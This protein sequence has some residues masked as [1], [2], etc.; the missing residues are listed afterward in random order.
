MDHYLAGNEDMRAYWQKDSQAYN[1]SPAV[2]RWISAFDRNKLS[3]PPLF[4]WDDDGRRLETN[5]IPPPI[6]RLNR[7]KKAFD[8]AGKPNV[9]NAKPAQSS[10]RGKAKTHKTPNAL[11]WSKYYDPVTNTVK[12]V[13][14]PMHGKPGPH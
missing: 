7:Q 3:V 4:L 8:A 6:R 11:K 2:A 1:V 5:Y 12:A 13:A 10:W 14:N 9:V